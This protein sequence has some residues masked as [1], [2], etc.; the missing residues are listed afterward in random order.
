MAKILLITLFAQTLFAQT[1]AEVRKA[2]ERALPVL[3]S[4]AANFVTNVPA[5]PA[6]TIF[7]RCWR[8]TSRASAALRSTRR[9]WTPSKTRPFGHSA[10][11]R[12]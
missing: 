9:F 2:V 1:E 11:R 12:R 8:F 10:A 3:E 7:C 4:S 6:I 5:F